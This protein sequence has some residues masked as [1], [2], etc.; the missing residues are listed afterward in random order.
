MGNSCGE[1]QK[2]RSRKKKNN[3]NNNRDNDNIEKANK[4]NNNFIIN[5]NKNKSNNLRLNYYRNDTD[6]I[7][8]E[9]LGNN[10]Y[11]NSFIQILLHCPHFIETL[12]SDGGSQSR[13]SLTYFLIK[14]SETYYSEYLEDIR[15]LMEEYYNKFKKNQ[16]CDSQDFGI[17]LIDK[18]IVDIKGVEN[19]S[20]F[21]EVSKIN[22]LDDIIQKEVSLEKLFVLIK[23]NKYYHS[24][25]KPGF[26]LNLDIHLTIPDNKKYCKL[27]DLLE[28]KFREYK[29]IKLPKILIITIDRV[30]LGKN[31]DSREIK[32][33]YKLNTKKY[34]LSVKDE[35]K[36]YFLFAVNK[37]YGDMYSGHYFCN[38]KIKDFWYLF[39][40]LKVIK[41]K[42]PENTPGNVVGLFYCQEI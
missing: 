32:F 31:Y 42:K 6:N 21:S 37:K 14:L 18:I 22:N 27:E 25:Y 40:D 4:L 35:R 36:K 41:G 24:N 29:I 28:H 5:D 11:L 33:P 9:N 26:D 16:Q 23:S 34:T 30:I 2:I 17:K 13:Y 1:N 39:D 38:I 3:I 19:S 10:C 8:L 20:V 15:K 7:G 12:K